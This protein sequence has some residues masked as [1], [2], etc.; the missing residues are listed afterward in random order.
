MNSEHAKFKLFPTQ[1]IKTKVLLILEWFQR[2][3]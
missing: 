2:N 1:A 3:L